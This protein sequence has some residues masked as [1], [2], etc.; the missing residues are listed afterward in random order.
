MIFESINDNV[1]LLELSGDEMDKYHLTYDILNDNEKAKS[2]LKA[3]LYS[4]DKKHKLLKGEKILVEAMPTDNGGCFF[5]LTFS[6]RRKI[7]YR[8]KKN[9]ISAIFYTD[10]LDNM[11]DFLSVVRKSRITEQ[12]TEAYSNGNSYFLYIPKTSNELN[13]L[14]C[15]YGENA[16]KINY[17]WL[18]EYGKFLGTIYLQ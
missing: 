3:L 8:I 14:I 4:I 16:E 17:E 11:L 15:E 10:S 1:M 13:T 12:K 6:Q 9:N 7:V 18:K 2:A 5:I